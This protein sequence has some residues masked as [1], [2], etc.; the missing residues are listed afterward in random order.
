MLTY[1]LTFKWISISTTFAWVASL[2]I[3]P[4]LSAF[5]VYQNTIF[6]LLNIFKI[7]KT[8]LTYLPSFSTNASFTSISSRFAWFTFGKI[9][10]NCLAIKSHQFLY[11]MG[12]S[13]NS[14]FLF[15][16]ISL[17]FDQEIRISFIN[18]LS[19]C[20]L[21][22]NSWRSIPSILTISSISPTYV[23]L[24]LTWTKYEGFRQYFSIKASAW[25]AWHSR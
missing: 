3:F 14:L 24:Q 19:S 13:L 21:T 16:S 22:I 9:S 11:N 6:I 1:V 8:Y 23:N 15:P 7:W 4:R 2:T 18:R 10:L 12:K 17:G 20:H 25:F 5:L